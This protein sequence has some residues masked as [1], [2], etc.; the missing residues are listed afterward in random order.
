MRFSTVTLLSLSLFS[1]ACD[2]PGSND[3]A[4]LGHG[5][6][7]TSST[8]GNDL[9]ATGNDLATTMPPTGERLLGGT[10]ME[11][12]WRALASADGFLYIA[13]T[14][15][16]TDGDLAGTKSDLDGDIWVV[17]LDSAFAIVWSHVYGGT[18]NFDRPYAL[19]L[20]S[21]GDLLVLGE[22]TEAGK[23]VGTSYG[24]TDFWLFK[25]APSDGALRW[26][27]TIG[28]TDDDSPR[29]VREATLPSGDHEYTAIGSTRGSGGNVLDATNGVA[30]ALIGRY[31]VAGPTPMDPPAPNP[32]ATTFGGNGVEIGVGFFGERIVGTTDSTAGADLSGTTA[33]G[34]NDSFVLTETVGV[35]RFGGDQHDQIAQVLP[36][37]VFVGRTGSSSDEVTCNTHAVIGGVGEMWIGKLDDTGLAMSVCLGGD[38]GDEAFAIAKRPDGGYVVVGAG[39]SGGGITATGTGA[40]VVFLDASLAVTQQYFRPVASGEL[41][42]VVVMADGR[43]VGIGHTSDQSGA[44][45]A[46]Q[47]GGN[48]IWVAELTP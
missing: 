47:H 15:S 43:V 45:A 18:G 19:E 39:K 23:Q 24:G 31:Y 2:P 41:R 1:L 48:D 26:E 5:G 4:D 34:W 40:L 35:V 33:R 44:F 46:Q 14:T 28:S 20:A 6:D 12:G 8:A 3:G 37:G 42:A 10:G 16:S 29:A 22:I 7:L 32:S 11:Y 38:G 27:T 17:K 25:I 9:G 30:D 21:D 13:G 36:D